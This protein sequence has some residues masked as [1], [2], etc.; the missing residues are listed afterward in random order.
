MCPRTQENRKSSILH[1]AYKIGHANPKEFTYGNVSL[2]IPSEI[3]TSATLDNRPYVSV[4]D[5]VIAIR[6]ADKHEVIFH[7]PDNL[8]M[9]RVNDNPWRDGKEMNIRDI[10]EG[11]GLDDQGIED[12]PSS[13]TW[14]G[15]FLMSYRCDINLHQYRRDHDP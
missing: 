3:G 13:G 8:G 15:W 4:R 1:T 2:P 5:V 6:N 12:P 9:Y 11:F 14:I 10:V 7:R